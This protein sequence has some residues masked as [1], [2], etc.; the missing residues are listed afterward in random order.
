MIRNRLV[1]AVDPTTSVLGEAPALLLDHECRGVLALVI[2]GSSI[3]DAVR[4]AY[5][6]RRAHFVDVAVLPTH[7][8][9]TEAW[10]S[11]CDLYCGHLGTDSPRALEQLDVLSMHVAHGDEHEVTAVLDFL[12]GVPQ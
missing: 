10:A 5:R 6:L 9:R 4:E 12:T 8:F 3:V 2:K 7:P 11:L 1:A